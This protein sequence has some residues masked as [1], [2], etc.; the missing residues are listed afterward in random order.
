ILRTGG[1]NI[2]RMLAS[3]RKGSNK[4][5]DML[6]DSATPDPTPVTDKLRKATPISRD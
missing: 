2:C 6:F 5:E 3:D 1:L 4:S